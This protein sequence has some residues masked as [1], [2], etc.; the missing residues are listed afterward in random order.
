[1]SESGKTQVP[2]SL[3]AAMRDE[4]NSAY[5]VSPSEIGVVKMEEYAPFSSPAGERKPMTQF[6]VNTASSIQTIKLPALRD[7]VVKLFIANP[8]GANYCIAVRSRC[9]KF[10]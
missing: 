2:S 5:S 6:V 4:K 7:S 3:S 1:M 9:R 8:E 10:Q